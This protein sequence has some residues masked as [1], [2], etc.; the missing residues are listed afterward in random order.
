MQ[1][2]ISG[3]GSKMVVKLQSGRGEIFRGASNRT[4]ALYYN[5]QKFERRL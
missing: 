5:F 1:Q 2:R 3:I 4:E